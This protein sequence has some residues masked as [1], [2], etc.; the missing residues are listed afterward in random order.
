MNKNNNFNTRTLNDLSEIKFASDM[1]N[2]SE[3]IFSDYAESL[4]KQIATNGTKNKR[5]Q[6]RKFYDEI[7]MWDDKV[8]LDNNEYNKSKVLFK[9]MKAKIAYSLGREYID[10]NFKNMFNTLIDQVNNANTLRQ[11]KLFFEAFMGYYRI[12]KKD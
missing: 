3:K 1:A 7:I 2:L 4:A 8:N 11:F 5:T 12:E 6:I 9:M 10:E